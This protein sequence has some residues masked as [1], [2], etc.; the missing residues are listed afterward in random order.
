[1]AILEYFRMRRSGATVME[2][3][4][5]LQLPQSSASALLRTLVALD[6]LAYNRRRRTY[7]A[8]ARVGLLSAGVAPGV[9]GDSRLPHA[10]EELHDKTGEMVLLATHNETMVRFIEVIESRNPMRLHLPVGSVRPLPHSGMGRLFLS[11]FPE[12]KIRGLVHLFNAESGSQRRIKADELLRE[13]DVV[14]KRGYLVALNNF[15]VGA[16]LV[17]MLLRT[18]ANEPQLAVAICGPSEVIGRNSE[19]YVELMRQ[20]LGWQLKGRNA[21][22]SAQN[23][24]GGK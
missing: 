18:E 8:T 16:G 21:A 7:V 9:F 2:L 20:A 12:E 15:I 14:R 6:Y 4:R 24:R 1:M 5:T 22:R 10:L 23:M 19:R 17:S 11:S 3:S 13:I